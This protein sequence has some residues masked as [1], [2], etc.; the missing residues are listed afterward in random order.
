MIEEE[1]TL[2]RS[3]KGTVIYIAKIF[4]DKLLEFDSQ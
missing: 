1:L 3:Q 4:E 2:L